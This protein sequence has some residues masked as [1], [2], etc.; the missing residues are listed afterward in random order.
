MHICILDEKF[1]YVHLKP[2]GREG[3][4]QTPL[5]TSKILY[6]PASCLT[7]HFKCPTSL[8]AIENEQH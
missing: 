1:H 2:V 8:P 4:T 7:V 5:L 3:F 6:T